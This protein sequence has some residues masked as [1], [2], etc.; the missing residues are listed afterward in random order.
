[1]VDRH[2]D[3]GWLLHIGAGLS[4]VSTLRQARANGLRTI[5]VDIDPNAPGLAYATESI[6]RSRDDLG[7]ILR[8]VRAFATQHPLIGCSTTSSAAAALDAAAA[9]REEYN[10]PG[11]RS[12]ALTALGDRSIWKERLASRSI[13]TPASALISTPE[14]LD[15]F[16]DDQPNTL[17]KP[18]SG[19]RGSL[20]VARVRRGEM[21][22]RD[23]YEE[24]RDHSTSDLVL[25]EAFVSGDEYS[26]DGI[27]R[28]GTF[29]MLHLGRK[30]SARNLRG[31]LPTGYAWGAPQKGVRC[32][33]DP[34]W[35]EYQALGSAAGAALG[36]DD[37]FLSLDVIDDG[38]TTFIV[39]IGC[40]LDAKVD[41]GLAFSG[42]NV[43]ELECAV[44]TGTPWQLVREPG[45]LTRG[46]AV[47]FFYSDSDG[48]LNRPADS[49]SRTLDS[50]AHHWQVI[51][52]P[53]HRIRLEWEKGPDAQLE[54]PRSVSDLVVC[55]FVEAEDRNRAWMRCNEIEG[56][57]LFT[58][59]QIGGDNPPETNEWS[60]R[61]S[62]SS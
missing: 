58:V 7:G 22:R 55:V 34:R 54:R 56:S 33:D 60:A 10:L 42:F 18:E 51:E 57:A 36:M 9:I 23:L 28:N 6:E 46:Y 19:G 8:D 32:D 38:D 62:N 21:R 4:S 11:L 61:G 5:A 1:M 41:R 40:Q 59:Q 48:L 47:R 49:E 52:M 44:A 45:V 37:T 24:A 12:A 35:N 50:S 30:F 20:G 16:L 31:T 29:Q 25:A 27:I 2:S 3:S 43:A 15:Q 53:A 17:V 13:A 26:I 14:Q 39:D